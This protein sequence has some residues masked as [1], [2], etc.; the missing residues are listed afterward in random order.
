MADPPRHDASDRDGGGRRGGGR[1]HEDGRPVVVADFS[2]S[3]NA[4]AAGD[5]FDI[6]YAIARQAPELRV[7]TII[8]DPA[9]ADRAFAEGLGS[10]FRPA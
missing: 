5:N 4:G 6:A 2:D 7:G 9:L 10:T 8:N 3:P 1:R